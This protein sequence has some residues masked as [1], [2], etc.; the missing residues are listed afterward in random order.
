VG[1]SPSAE[2]GTRRHRRSAS[3]THDVFISYSSIDKPTA[4]AICA[5]MENNAIRCWIAPRDVISGM[6]WDEQVLEA[7]ENARAM[8]L[9]LTKNSNRSPEV[10]KEVMAAVNAGTVVIP[11]RL[12]EVEPSRMLTYHLGRVHW[13]DAFTPPLEQHALVLVDTVNRFLDETPHASHRAR[14]IER[15]TAKAHDDLEP[16]APEAT[17]PATAP[18]AQPAAPPFVAD[19]EPEARIAEQITADTTL[20]PAGPDHPAEPAPSPNL[21]DRA[22]DARPQ[23]AAPAAAPIAADTTLSPAGPGHP[24]EP[25]QGPNLVKSVDAAAL[26]PRG[27]STVEPADSVRPAPSAAPT[28]A[29]KASRVGLLLG[30]L[31]VFVLLGLMLLGSHT[32][33]AANSDTA[34]AAMASDAG[35]PAMA[36]APSASASL[37]AGNWAQCGPPQPTVDGCTATL[38]SA[39]LTTEDR[40]VA[41]ASRGNAYLDQKSYQLAINDY[42]QSLELIPNSTPRYNRS[43]VYRGR[44]NAYLW[45][46]K[47]ALSIQDFSDAIELDPSDAD[48]FDERGNAYY[49]LKKWDLAIQDYSQ[50]ITLAP[51]NATYLDDRGEAYTWKG[52]WA[53]AIQDYDQALKLKPD[54]A[55][56]ISDRKAAMTAQ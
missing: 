47:L 48:T 13:L 55:Q 42:T 20:R 29:P 37:P 22:G 56:A 6:L 3:A 24:S 15:K 31:V 8:V 41:L 33:P 23:S 46:N 35:A 32:S 49:D 51:D 7:I 5:V 36:A 38:A 14:T 11:I 45:L 27:P 9:V 44:G 1:R 30:G 43:F 40:A 26:K 16:P 2:P 53:R 28:A 50:A 10:Q 34:T 39:D 12:E 21:V 54:F 25:G 52:E 19:A 4:D 18:H 17:K